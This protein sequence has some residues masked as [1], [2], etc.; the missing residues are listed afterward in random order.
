LSAS[1]SP[2]PASAGSSGPSA[3]I[4]GQIV[5][6]L[7]DLK[8]REALAVVDPKTGDPAV[9]FR[10]ASGKVVGYDAICTHA[11][12]TVEFDSGSELLF[13]PCHGAVFDPAHSARVLAGPTRQPLFELPVTVDPTTGAISMSA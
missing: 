12:C 10:L 3:S 8:P 1:G 11:G 6:R 5:A 13:C 4:G 9:L 2:A 7:A